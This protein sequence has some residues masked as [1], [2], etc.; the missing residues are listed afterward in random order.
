MERDFLASCIAFP[1]AGGPLLAALDLEH[2]LL[3]PS[4]RRAAA[5]LRDAPDAE[6]PPE[7]EGVLT[8]LRV[9][10]ASPDISRTGLEIARLQI[11]LGRVRR[12]IQAAPSGSKTALAKRREA[13]QAELNE[14]MDT[15]AG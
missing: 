3:T 12:D 5:H 10:A 2:D 7:L 4:A 9:R 13:L 6:P 11:A 8:A 15:A 1:D 14:A